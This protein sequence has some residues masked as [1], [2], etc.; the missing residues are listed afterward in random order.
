MH[1]VNA[2]ASIKPSSIPSP[3]R[4]RNGQRVRA[5]PILAVI[6]LLSH[7]SNQPDRYP[8]TPIPHTSTLLLP[9]PQNTA[10]AP[11][12]SVE[13]AGP[14]HHNNWM[15]PSSIPPLLLLLL[16]LLFLLLRQA[17]TTH[18]FAI[19]SSSGSKGRPTTMIGRHH[20][21]LLG[22]TLRRPSLQL[23]STSSAAGGGET[24]AGDTASAQ[25]QPQSPLAQAAATF[26]RVFPPG[27]SDSGVDHRPVVLFDGVC[28][29]C[30]RGIDAVL[31]LDVNRRLRW[32]RFGG[33]GGR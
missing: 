23:R 25:A 32:V 3:P 26:A 12:A 5:C 19:R 30:N 9:L 20:R 8:L 15:P 14:N 29:F 17:P 13:P 31:R 21:R 33:T 11:A 24:T 10:L 4:F 16:P 2:R 1:A 22:S 6:L 28:A 7:H 18:A 27:T